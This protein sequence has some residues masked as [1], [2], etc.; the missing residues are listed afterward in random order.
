MRK[1]KY[2]YILA[3][4]IFTFSARYL[5]LKALNQYSVRAAR[6][7]MSYEFKLSLHTLCPLRAK[8]DVFP[9]L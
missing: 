6:D 5:T 2:V 1:Q 4:V 3:P 8:K 9:K 7:G